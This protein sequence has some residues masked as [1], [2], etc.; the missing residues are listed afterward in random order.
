MKRDGS[1]GYKQSEA[2]LLQSNDILTLLNSPPGCA[3]VIPRYSARSVAPMLASQLRTLA[4]YPPV[5]A[6]AAPKSAASARAFFAT[7]NR[8]SFPL[9]RLL[10]DDCACLQT[11]RTPDTHVC[12]GI[13]KLLLLL[14]HFYLEHLLHVDLHLLHFILVLPLLF[15]QLRQRVPTKYT[16]TAQSENACTGMDAKYKCFCLFLYFRY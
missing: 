14:P 5:R 2:D 11:M 9:Q 6:P 7:A 3:C 8:P 15:L 13:L 16:R 1:Y 12:F 10:S 4:S